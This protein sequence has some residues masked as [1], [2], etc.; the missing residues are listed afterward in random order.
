[1]VHSGKQASDA[2][3]REV[4]QLGMERKGARNDGV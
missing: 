2:V 4:D 3:Q 1:M